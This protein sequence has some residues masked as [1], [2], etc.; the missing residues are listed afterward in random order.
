M[1]PCRLDNRDARTRRDTRGQSPRTPTS[2]ENHIF[3]IL[4]KFLCNSLGKRHDFQCLPVKS[5]GRDSCLPAA[6]PS[7]TFPWCNARTTRRPRGRD[8]QTPSGQPG[9]SDDLARPRGRAGSAGG[10]RRHEM[11]PYTRTTLRPRGRDRQTP[12]GQP[13][14]LDDPPPPPRNRAGSAGARRRHEMAPYTRTTRRLRGRDRQ[15]PGGQP[16]RLDDP[17]PP[18]RNRAEAMNV[19]GIISGF[20]LPDNK[21]WGQ[22]SRE[23]QRESTPSPLAGEG[24]GEGFLLSGC[25]TYH[26]QPNRTEAP[27]AGFCPRCSARSP[28]S[29]TSSDELKANR[30]PRR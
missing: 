9:R 14:R 2:P 30:L 18:P 7:T 17:P 25:S 1:A 22:G 11:A 16:C 23:G 8:R 3:C 27:C 20:P 13:C 10:R 12:G 26:C 21:C 6:R 19:P 15:T 4:P 29:V 5:E 28:S 24:R